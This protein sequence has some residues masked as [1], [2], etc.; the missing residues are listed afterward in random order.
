MDHSI[1]KKTKRPAGIG[2]ASQVRLSG[3]RQ[4]FSRPDG[5]PPP[6]V[7]KKKKKKPNRSV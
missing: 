7:A 1:G 5:E 2:G 3:E 6:G 4:R